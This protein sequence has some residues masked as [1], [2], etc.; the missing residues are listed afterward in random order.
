M[1]GQHLRFKLEETMGVTTKVSDQVLLKLWSE[2][3][4]SLAAAEGVE[5]P[6]P[7]TPP[8]AVEDKI[9]AQKAEEAEEVANARA[10][11]QERPE[12]PEGEEETRQVKRAKSSENQVQNEAENQVQQN[13]AN[14]VHEEDDNEHMNVKDP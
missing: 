13:E 6:S 2:F 4:E 9:A 3:E 8:A 14:Q 7:C 5:V 12:E 1:A 10:R 11:G